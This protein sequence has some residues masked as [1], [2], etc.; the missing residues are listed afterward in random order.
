MNFQIKLLQ[1]IIK[2]FKLGYVMMVASLKKVNRLIFFFFSLMA[3]TN[4][5]TIR[6]NANI[7]IKENEIFTLA[8]IDRT[9][10][11]EVQ[12]IKKTE[13]YPLSYS[14]AIN[15]LEFKLLNDQSLSSLFHYTYLSEESKSSR[16]LTQEQILKTM[17]KYLKKSRV[18]LSQSELDGQA[19]PKLKS[20]S[21]LLFILSY[22][23]DGFIALVKFIIDRKNGTISLEEIAD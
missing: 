17:I 14:E 11:K 6:A 16:E 3:F 23:M 9:P 4:I 10:Q 21:H 15:L 13:K 18:K 19:W 5:Y 7:E 20:E 1:I 12:K 2:F 8:K 22:N